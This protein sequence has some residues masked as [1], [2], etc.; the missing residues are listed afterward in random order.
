MAKQ[1]ENEDDYKQMLSSSQLSGTVQLGTEIDFYT[2]LKLCDY[3][4]L[5]QKNY[6][7]V[8]FY[9]IDAN[10]SFIHSKTLK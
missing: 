5:Y 8:F 1:I 6:F 4:Q 7:Y 3:F 9:K 10:K 2:F